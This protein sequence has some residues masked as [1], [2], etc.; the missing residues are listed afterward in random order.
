MNKTDNEVKGMPMHI[1]VGCIVGGVYADYEFYFVS[2]SI[3]WSFG[4]A[5]ITCCIAMIISW[6]VFRFLMQLH[7]RIAWIYKYYSNSI[8]EYSIIMGVVLFPITTIFVYLLIPF[9]RQF[10]S[11]IILV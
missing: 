6:L 4:F 8:D 10:L 5:I 11:F 9:I 3:C 7:T 1:G 2:P